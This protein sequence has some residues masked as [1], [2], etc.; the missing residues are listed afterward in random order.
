VISGVWRQRAAVDVTGGSRLV[1]AQNQILD[2]DGAG[3]RLEGVKHSLIAN[4]I[5]R[6]D[7]PDEKRSREPS[8][9][10]VKSAENQISSNLLGNGQK[11]Q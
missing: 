8:L 2:S 3:L 6:D 10:L 11:E 5:I 9:L 7:R 4:N 1:I